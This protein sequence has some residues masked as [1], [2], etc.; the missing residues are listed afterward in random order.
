[1]GAARMILA[2]LLTQLLAASNAG[3]PVAGCPD[4]PVAAVGSATFVVVDSAGP[5]ELSFTSGT[6]L[7]FCRRTSETMTWIR[8]AE[9]AENEGGAGRHLDIDVCHFGEG[10]V[11]QAME[12]RARPCPGG[13]TWGVWWHQSSS[14]VYANPA[15]SS[16]CELRI[17]AEDSR[18]AG[19]FICR[20]LVNDDG[21]ATVDLLEGR[22]E[23]DAGAAT[24]PA[25]GH[26][27]R[28]TPLPA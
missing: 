10:G 26:R 11:F 23:F 1:M 6:N 8:I 9:S 20:G 5:S 24:P 28:G 3:V 18:I 25:S 17:S 7:L 27:P 16:P 12:A 19:S 14:D 21:T 2:I 4:T 13:R 22:F 15:G